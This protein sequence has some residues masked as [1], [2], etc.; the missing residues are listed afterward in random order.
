MEE[1]G[2]LLGRCTWGDALSQANE[3]RGTGSKAGPATKGE[4][5]PIEA[6][7]WVGGT[8]KKNRNGKSY[9][10]VTNDTVS[11][12]PLHLIFLLESKKF[13][14]LPHFLRLHHSEIRAGDKGQ[15]QRQFV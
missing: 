10:N 7:A 1:R 8:L 14:L 15:W 3:Y 4:A 13:C 12:G 5:W 6:Q 2:K 9:S 11:K